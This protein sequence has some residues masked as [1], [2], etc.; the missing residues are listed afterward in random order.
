[1]FGVHGSGH[2]WGTG[3]RLCWTGEQVDD[4]EAGSQGQSRDSPISHRCGYRNL[5]QGAKAVVCF[6]SQ[7]GQGRLRVSI[8]ESCYMERR[9]NLAASVWKGRVYIGRSN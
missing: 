2:R 1:M 3:N 9:Y 4:Q 6:G 8:R 5:G 7:T